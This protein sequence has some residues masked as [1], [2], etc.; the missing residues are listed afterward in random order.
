MKLREIIIKKID[1]FGG[2]N[3][4]I[5]NVEILRF[6][7]PIDKLKIIDNIILYYTLLYEF[8]RDH[9][10]D[11]IKYYDLRLET[12]S[13]LKK[14]II[15]DSNLKSFFLHWFIDLIEFGNKYVSKTRKLA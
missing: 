9:E 3:S 1:K 10:A 12:I 5:N 4:F 11:V 13:I 14:L 7:V 15:N 8:P 2:L 6:H